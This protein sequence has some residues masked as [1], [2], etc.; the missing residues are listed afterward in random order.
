MG[1]LRVGFAKA[2]IT[3]ESDRQTIYHRSGRLDD[4]GTPIRDRLYARATAFE[5]DGDQAVWLAADLLCIDTRLRA[6]VTQRTAERGIRPDSVALLATHTHSAPSVA[7]FH[8]V[9]PTPD[10][11]L[12]SLAEALAET[13]VHAAER[14]RPATL[15]FAAIDVDLSVNRREVGRLAQVNDLGSPAGRVDPTA[16][17]AVLR[18]PDSGTTAL[19]VNYAAHPLTMSSGNPQISADFPGRA[20]A[21]LEARPGVAFA[22]FLQGC[23]GDVNVRIH[24]GEA[25]AGLVGG[26]L[27]DTVDAAARS[28]RPSGTDAV[29]MVTRAVSLPWGAVATEDEARVILETCRGDGHADRRRR[30]WARGVCEAWRADRVPASADVLVQALRVGDGVFLAL[31]GEVFSR[32]GMAIRDQADAGN[33]FVCAYANSCEVGYVPTAS[34]FAEGGYEVDVAPTYYGLFQLSPACEDILVRAGVEAV[35]SVA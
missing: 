16:R 15:A 4:A 35:R 7:A 33:L 31:P 1:S 34:A 32:I 22:Q 17:V 29:R 6:A 19:L 10:T 25:E 5:A 30:S 23:A 20:V 24:G 28:A 11:Y 2:D 3:P 26:L 18:F 12:D 14:V 21:G 13:C 9:D 8:G 27:A